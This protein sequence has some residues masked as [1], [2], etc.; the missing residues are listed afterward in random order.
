M[1]K[2]WVYED[3]RGEGNIWLRK[4]RPYASRM[5]YHKGGWGVGGGGI[6]YIGGNRGIIRMSRVYAS[7]ICID[8][9][10]LENFNSIIYQILLSSVHTK[11]NL[12]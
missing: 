7:L 10:S 4:A 8:T 12:V 9:L 3:E 2:G 6:G 5:Q 11:A 1:D